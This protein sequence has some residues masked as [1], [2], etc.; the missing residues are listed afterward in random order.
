ML[1]IFAA[2]T[3]INAGPGAIDGPTI[4]PRM[5]QQPNNNKSAREKIWFLLSKPIAL[6][7]CFVFVCYVMT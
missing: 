5:N 6:F 2:V 7:H 4:E 3:D 1:G